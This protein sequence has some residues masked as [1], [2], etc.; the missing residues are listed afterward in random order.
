MER[1]YIDGE[2]ERSRS[3]SRAVVTRGGRTVYLAGV[4]DVDADG[5]PITGGPGAS[6]RAAFDRLRDA[7]EAAGGTLADI[8]TMTVH[9]T[10]AR[11]GDAFAKVRAEYFDA[12]AYPASTLVTCVALARPELTVE[13]TAIAVLDD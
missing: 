1:I 8:V 10:D 11:Y 4:V 13:I 2:R 3:Y 12:D 5:G 7:V 6:T 9:I